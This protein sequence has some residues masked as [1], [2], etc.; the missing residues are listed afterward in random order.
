MQIT[1]KKPP[2]STIKVKGMTPGDVFRSVEYPGQFFLRIPSTMI[3]G[4]AFTIPVTAV[5]LNT[6]HLYNLE[7]EMEVV[8]VPT[9]ILRFDGATE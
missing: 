6:G 1:N 5:D 2:E 7:P 4:I 3:D 8:P 9:A